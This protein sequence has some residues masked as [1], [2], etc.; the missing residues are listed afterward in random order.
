MR[1]FKEN[2]LTFEEA[3]KL[4][5][6]DFGTGKLFWL[7]RPLSMFKTKKSFATWN[8]RYAGKE[9]FTAVEKHGYLHGAVHNHKQKAHRVMWLLHT[10]EWPIGQIDHINGDRSDNRI[11]NLR[12]VSPAENARNM[13]RPS[14]NKSGAIGVC[15]H[16]SAGKWHAQIKSGGCNR[17]LGLFENFEA[18][19]AARK[20]AEA[21]YGF[22]KNHGR[23]A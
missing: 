23:A 19:V 21:E 13:R 22:H 14:D 11:E 15:W 4:L 3:S 2:P 16:K 9:A 1:Q 12:Q 8:A 20:A 18:A 17:H 5:H 7:P 10:G 6:A